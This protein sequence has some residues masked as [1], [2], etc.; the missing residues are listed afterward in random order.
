M[1]V[2]GLVLAALVVV[3]P[4]AGAAGRQEGRRPAFTL[5]SRVT[6]QMRDGSSAVSEEVRYVSAGGGFRFV[7]TGAD[8]KVAEERVFEP[9]RGFF[10]VYHDYELLVKNKRV[11]PELSDKPAPTAEQLRASPRFL[12][13]EAV[14]GH[15]AYVHRFT[16]ERTGEPEADHYYA[17]E[18]G[19]VPLK[20]VLYRGGRPFGVSEPVELRFGEP[21]AAQ[22]KAPDYEVSEMAPIMGGV[23]NGKAVER[24]TP[25]WP[26]EAQEVTGTVTVQVLVSEEGK[27]M[28][29][30]AVSGPGLLR[31]AAVE[32][33]RQSKFSPTK[34]S[35][36]PV[37]I[38]G[39]LVYKFARD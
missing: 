32:A 39:V 11:L 3:A 13:T 25:V 30:W 19:H 12:R 18:L 16:D 1:R 9:G 17:P 2:L 14:L 8:G 26:R 35:G 36:Q 29:A 33:A 24:P 7:R 38:A 31:Q 20:T 22:L 37:K 4:S 10:S 21:E 15:T 23:L 34:L 28:K 5:R 27:V 6:L